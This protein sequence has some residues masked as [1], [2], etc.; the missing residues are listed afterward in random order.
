M[1]VDDEHPFRGL[2][3]SSAVAGIP[4]ADD[5]AVEDAAWLLAVG[6]PDVEA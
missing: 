6:Y 1:T 3:L 5:L 2:P 4:W